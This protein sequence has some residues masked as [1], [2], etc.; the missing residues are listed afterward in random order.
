MSKEID[1]F[2]MNHQRMTEVFARAHSVAQGHSYAGTGGDAALR[3][4]VVMGDIHGVERIIRHGT[5]VNTTL[6]PDGD[7]PL[8]K[9][10]L[11]GQ[12]DLAIWLIEHGAN[13]EKPLKNGRTPLITA[14]GKG[15]AR[16]VEKLISA[17]VRLDATMDNGSSA[18]M[19]AVAKGFADVAKKLVAAGAATNLRDKEGWGLEDFARIS[20]MDLSWLAN[21]RVGCDARDSLSIS[22][23][24]SG[25]Y[26]C[27]VDYFRRHPFG[28]VPNDMTVLS[29]LPPVDR[30]LIL[31]MVLF[32]GFG[33]SVVIIDKLSMAYLKAGWEQLS[34]E[35]LSACYNGGFLDSRSYNFFVDKIRGLCVHGVSDDYDGTL[36]KLSQY[37]IP[38]D[39]FCELLKAFCE[40]HLG[41]DVFSSISLL[42]P[43]GVVEMEF[44][45]A[46]RRQA[47]KAIEMRRK[48][49]CV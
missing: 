32:F 14:A 8:T 33:N 47:I 16:V 23:K 18:L 34:F 6:N 15:D 38:E 21:G 11:G 7:T 3:S 49:G 20:G 5:D 2:M 42:T 40:R 19:Y 10:I 9:S 43:R 30:C 46:E 44:F 37:Y 13:I 25:R 41:D 31:E 22:Q 17:G 39:P 4:A 48:R 27:F 45:I 1:E 12:T 24:L 36:R 29:L 35:F 26:D 28:S